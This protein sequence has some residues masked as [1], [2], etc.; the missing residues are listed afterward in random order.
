MWG[1]AK[2]SKFPDRVMAMPYPGP[3]RPRLCLKRP[4]LC[5]AYGVTTIVPFMWGCKP[6]KYSKVPGFVNTKA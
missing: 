3:K 1:K 5:F 2:R 4:S 6:Q